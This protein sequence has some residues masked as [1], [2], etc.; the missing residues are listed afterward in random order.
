MRGIGIAEIPEAGELP[1]PWLLCVVWA[2]HGIYF[3]FWIGDIVY[4]CGL[5]DPLIYEIPFSDWNIFVYHE[6]SALSHVVV[7]P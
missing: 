3:M 7:C 5:I 2:N 6:S 1:H 4:I